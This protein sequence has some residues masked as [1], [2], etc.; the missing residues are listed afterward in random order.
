[1]FIAEFL[2]Y[3]ESY[4]LMEIKNA[5][6]DYSFKYKKD[7]LNAP[8]NIIDIETNNINPPNINIIERDIYRGKIIK[9]HPQGYFIAY[10]PSVW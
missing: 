4:D 2:D 5:L 3:K 7:F 9:E 1:M 8:Y 10:I 6:A